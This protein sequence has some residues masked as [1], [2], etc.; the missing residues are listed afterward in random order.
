MTDK[1][2]HPRFGESRVVKLDGIRK[3][4]GESLSA[5]LVD[6]AALQALGLGRGI[7]HSESS[8]RVSKATLRRLR[9]K[10]RAMDRLL[11]A[12]LDDDGPEGVA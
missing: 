8:V 7:P 9:D 2:I 4:S 12:L 3:P 11:S 1:I 10:A 5:D 6:D